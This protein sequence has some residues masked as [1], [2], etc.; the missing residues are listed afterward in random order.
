MRGTAARRSGFRRRRAVDGGWRHRFSSKLTL[1]EL[2][3]RR[4]ALQRLF[5]PMVGLGLV[6]ERNHRRDR[7]RYGSS[8]SL[9]PS[10]PMPGLLEA[11]ERAVEVGCGRPLWPTVPRAKSAGDVSRPG[12]VVGEDRGVEPVDGVVG[13]L[14]RVLLVVG[15]DHAEH[16]ARRSPPA[17]CV[18][19]LSTSA[20][21]RRLDVVAA[22]EMLGPATACRQGRALVDALGDVALD[23]VALAL[24]SPAGPSGGG[25]ERVA[26]PDLRRRWR[27]ARRRA[28]RGG[29]AARR[30]G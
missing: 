30:C 5:E 24:A 18:D 22:V 20:E 26:D 19:E 29:C 23:A 13:D 8:P 3:D 28:R 14:D 1:T 6:V 16:R 11:A 7:R 12:R 17:R 15:R 9:P 27:R 25:V 2:P 10:R 21:D 4:G